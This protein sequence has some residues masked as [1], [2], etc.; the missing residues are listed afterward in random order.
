MFG[1]GIVRVPIS[2]Q[3]PAQVVL[4]QSDRWYGARRVIVDDTYVYALDPS[5]VMRFSKSAF[6][7]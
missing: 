6:G 3:G 2:G 5:Y 7:P 4:L 1:K